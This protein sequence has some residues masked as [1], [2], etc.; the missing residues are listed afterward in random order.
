LLAAAFLLFMLFNPVLWPYL[1]NPALVAALAAVAA[2][3]RWTG[4]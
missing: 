2:S 1:Y 4:K 3:T